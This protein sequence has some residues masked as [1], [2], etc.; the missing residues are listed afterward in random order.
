MRKEV[1]SLRFTDV[2]D[3]DARQTFECGQ[4]FRWARERDGSYTG[5]V[6]GHFANVRYDN[7]EDT[8]TVWSDYM[9]KSEGLR[10]RFWRDY[11]DLDRDYASI[12]RKLSLGDPVMEEAVFRAGGIRV[13]HQEPWETLVSYLISQNN[14]I[15]RIR[16]CIEMLCRSFGQR[17]GTFSGRELY[18]F[19][20]IRTL[21]QLY[22][23]DIDVCK[24]GYRA[25]YL[26]ELSRQVDVDGGAFLATGETADAEK[27]EGYLLSLSGVGPKVAHCVML[28]SMRKFDRFPI[29]VWVHRAMHRLYG[30]AEED[31]EGMRAF[32]G[33]R[34]GALAG[35]AQMYLFYYM[36]ALEDTS[37]RL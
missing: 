32:A 9:P 10:A 5:V 12:K 11:L 22:E 33:E 6:Q 31:E 26:A 28:F 15:P 23:E 13:L 19:P 7:E 3:F 1:K 30:F 8:L 18:A 2:R 16:G 36:R 37:G 35:F 34:F 24:I 20:T 27:M 29:D 21:S 4:C 25:R 17:L 14:N